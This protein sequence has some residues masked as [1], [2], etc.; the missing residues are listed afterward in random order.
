MMVV[1]EI[2]TVRDGDWRV[3]SVFDDK[4]LAVLEAT[5]LERSKHQPAVRVVEE[6]FDQATDQKVTRTVYR[7]AKSGADTPP[8]AAPRKA[9]AP[10]DVN[11]PAP[12][13]KSAKPISR[14]PRR[15]LIGVLTLVAGIAFGLG[16]V[17]ALSALV[18]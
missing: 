1:Y 11:G 3:D 15:L 10:L 12:V 8:K 14:A 5:R 6:T 13:V 16:A 2:H 9:V 4:D 7:T 17:Y 18:G